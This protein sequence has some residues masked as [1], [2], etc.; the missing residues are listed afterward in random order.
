MIGAD[1]AFFLAKHLDGQSKTP[2]IPSEAMRREYLRCYDD[3]AAIHAICE[4][5]R[6]AATIDLEHDRIDGEKRI[7]A[8]LL[9]LWGAKGT[10]GALY[11]VVA[12]WRE[13]ASGPV[14]GKALDCG[15]LIQEE[16]PE[17]LLAELLPFLSVSE[18]VKP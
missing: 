6:A 9:A 2:G 8:P 7:T 18:S 12:T 14:G 3:P 1:P 5:Y 15:H 4:D 10:V 13:K 16:A 11:D 17:A